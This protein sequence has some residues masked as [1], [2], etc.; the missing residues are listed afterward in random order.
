MSKMFDIK[1]SF[2]KSRAEY[3]QLYKNFL[4]I[5]D[6]YSKIYQKNFVDLFSASTFS[7]VVPQWLSNKDFLTLLNSNNH[8][9]YYP[10]P[11]GDVALIDTFYKFINRIYG[12]DFCNYGTLICQGT[13]QA[14]DSI[15]RIT[16]GKIVFVM[17]STVTF[18]K[19]IPA[20]NGAEI[21]LIK[22]QCAMRKAT[23]SE[24]VR[25]R[26]SVKAI[27]ICK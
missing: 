11:N 22:H 2:K 24:F 14:I 10:S 4:Y 20:A 16:K 3:N 25:Y 15:S 21:V 17:D 1:D 6:Y 8:F 9:E 23:L 12:L 27:Q 19:S 26:A 7:N 13:M 5:N 18:A